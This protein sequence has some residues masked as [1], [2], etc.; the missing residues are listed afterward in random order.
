DFHVTG[1][2]TCALPI[3][4]AQAHLGR[5]PIEWLLEN[6]AVAQRWCLVH[7]T[8][9][10]NQELEG[11]AQRGAVVALCPTTEGNLGDGL[12]PTRRW[13]DL[14]GAFAIGSDSHVCLSPVDELRWLE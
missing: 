14:G 7:A 11:M 8:H 1:V 6:A 5:R 2:Q 13:L 4:A 3:F 9:V 10:T 12:F